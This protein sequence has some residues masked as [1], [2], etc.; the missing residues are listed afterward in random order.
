MAQ[1]HKGQNTKDEVK[2]KVEDEYE[3]ILRFAVEPLRRCAVVPLPIE[4]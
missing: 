3:I 4:I 2:V 1:R